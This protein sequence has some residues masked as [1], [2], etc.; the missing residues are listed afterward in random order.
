[1]TDIMTPAEMR[2]LRLDEPALRRLVLHLAAT[3]EADAA[4]KAAERVLDVRGGILGIVDKM[5]ADSGPLGSPERLHFDKMRNDAMAAMGEPALD[6][7]N[8]YQ[9]LEGVPP[10]ES[11][12]PDPERERAEMLEGV[13][14]EDRAVW[15]HATA[16]G[17]EF[18]W[19]DWVLGDSVVTAMGS[20]AE[21]ILPDLTDE[22]ALTVAAYAHRLVTGT[23]PSGVGSKPAPVSE[24]EPPIGTREEWPDFGIADPVPAMTLDEALNHATALGVDLR[25]FELQP[26]G[27][28]RR[29]IA[30]WTA[31]VSRRAGGTWRW[32]VFKVG[33][34]CMEGGEYRGPGDLPECLA[35]A[36][37][38]IVSESRPESMMYDVWDHM[39]RAGFVWGPEERGTELVWRRP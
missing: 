24:D 39:H 14:D 37:S 22:Q 35:R 19:C 32:S 33:R 6:P 5:H 34:L 25:G 17:F 23:E 36:K 21:I 28:Y 10:R 2:A 30:Q 31:K 9:P 16:L 26:D 18:D 20:W 7:R 27:S 12:L 3:A 38:Y 29:S 4:A 15:D 1:M 8:G 13:P 11:T